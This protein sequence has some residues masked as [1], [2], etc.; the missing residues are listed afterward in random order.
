[1]LWC[2]VNMIPLIKLLP[3]SLILML[4]HVLCSV[5]DAILLDKPVDVVVLQDSPASFNCST[6]STD[7]YN[8]DNFIAW[9]NSANASCSA[10]PSPCTVYYATFLNKTLFPNK[11][12]SSRYQVT[13]IDSSTGEHS[14]NRKSFQYVR[15]TQ[16]NTCAMI[17]Q[18]IP[19]HPHSLLSLV[20]S[21]ALYKPL[22]NFTYVTR[23]AIG[24]TYVT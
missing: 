5:N 24:Q 23:N 2:Q 18:R 9:F 1:M 19:M 10:F 11:T 20:S 12:L 8:G 15:R 4:T 6:N 3:A 7:P 22:I 14:R 16:V 13:S 17:L 21:P